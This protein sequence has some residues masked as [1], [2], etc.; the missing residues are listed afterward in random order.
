MQ[1][2]SLKTVCVR[3]FLSPDFTHTAFIK[4]GVIMIHFHQHVVGSLIVHGMI[5]VYM[6]LCT[7][8]PQVC[9]VV[10]QK[11]PR[12]GMTMWQIWGCDYV[13]LLWYDDLSMCTCVEPK[14]VMSRTRKLLEVK[15]RCDKWEDVTM[16]CFYD[17]MTDL[18]MWNLGMWCHAQK[19]S[20]PWPRYHWAWGI[21]HGMSHI[22]PQ[23]WWFDDTSYMRCM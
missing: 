6:W 12:S 8:R 9:D 4:C 16:W 13:M 11:T 15:W 1:L 17:M 21:E 19:N 23:M 3:K 18:S 22:L 10:N 14:Y 7:C 5:G 2:Y 20:S